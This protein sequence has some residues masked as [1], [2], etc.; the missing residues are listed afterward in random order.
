MYKMPLS[1]KGTCHKAQIKDPI[2]IPFFTLNC[3][4]NLGSIHPL[5]PISSRK[6]RADTITTPVIALI[7]ILNAS[8]PEVNVPQPK[9]FGEI[10]KPSSFVVNHD[11]HG[12]APLF[13]KYIKGRQI[14]CIVTG[15]NISA[16][17]SQ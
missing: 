14:I 16:K 11:C 8:S 9:L 1:K 3:F 7:R 4:I 12:K 2:T 10:Y 15:I 6:A 17:K 5:Q 13:K